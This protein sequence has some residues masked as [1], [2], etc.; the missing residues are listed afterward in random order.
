MDHAQGLDARA[1]FAVGK[2]CTVN[3]DNVLFAPML[4]ALQQ[5]CN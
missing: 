5:Y 4:H 3:V 1:Q 2:S